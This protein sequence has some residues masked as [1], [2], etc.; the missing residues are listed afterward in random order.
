M[1]VWGTFFDLTNNVAVELDEMSDKQAIAAIERAGGT[2][3]DVHW[4]WSTVRKHG[5]VNDVPLSECDF[6][7]SNGLIFEGKTALTV[8]Y[9]YLL[10]KTCTAATVK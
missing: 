7:T 10:K 9:Q 2:K 1:A 3:Y 5:W 4:T 6:S 8:L